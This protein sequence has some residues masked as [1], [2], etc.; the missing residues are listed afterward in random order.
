MAKKYKHWN[1]GKHQ[2]PIFETGLMADEIMRNLTQFLMNDFKISEKTDIQQHYV[3]QRF[4][5]A[6][7]YMENVCHILRDANSINALYPVDFEQR[8]I[9]WMSAKGYCFRLMALLDTISVFVH[10]DTNVQKYA[11][12]SEQ[13]MMLSVKI[14]NI[15]ISDDKRKKNS[16]PYVGN[17]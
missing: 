10:K 9:R 13:L 12:L 1:D 4:D 7:Q 14:Q 16:K 17:A 3:I 2:K 11:D 8:R 6:T 5:K 15:L